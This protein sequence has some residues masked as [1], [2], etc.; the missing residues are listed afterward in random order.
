MLGTVA[1]LRG[2]LSRSGVLDAERSTSI[3]DYVK[4]HCADSDEAIRAAGVRV[5]GLLVLPADSA[6]IDTHQQQICD[7]LDDVLWGNPDKVSGGALHDS[8]SL[9]RQRASWAFSNA[10]EARLRAKAPLIEADWTK[11]ARYCLAAAKDIEGVAVSAYRTSGTLLALLDLAFASKEGCFSLGRSLLEQLCR[12]L[13]TT[14]KPPKSKWNAASALDR[15]LASSVVMTHSLGSSASADGLVDKI[16]DSLCGSLT[17][18]VFKIRVS[19]ANALVSLCLDADKTPSQ[20]SSSLRLEMLGEQ[21]ARKIRTVA[22]ARLAELGEP[23]TSKEAALY[24]DELKRLLGTVVDTI[25]V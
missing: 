23:A 16:V 25:P 13:G 1:D 24:V 17:A 7:V 4:R 10:M 2:A 20:T 19:A 15:A 14:S 3:L 5:L 21:R 8:S 11:Y 6:H 12:V 18:K 9:V 22:M